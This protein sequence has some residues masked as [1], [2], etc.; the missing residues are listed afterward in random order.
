VK[1]RL[2]L[3]YDNDYQISFSN[4]DQGGVTVEIYLRLLE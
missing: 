3:Y 2:A 4:N 1:K